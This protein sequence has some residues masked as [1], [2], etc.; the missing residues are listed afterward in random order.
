MKRIG[1][2]QAEAAKELAYSLYEI[3]A[4]ILKDSGEAAAY[5]G[6][7]AVW[8]ELGSQAAQLTDEDLLG[9]AQG[10]LI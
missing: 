8:P 7:I 3:A 6:L 5:N 9:D 4:N 2:S 10:T 1:S